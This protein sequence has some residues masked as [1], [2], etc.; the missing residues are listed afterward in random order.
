MK[1]PLPLPEL[2]QINV[3]KHFMSPVTLF[4]GDETHTE[5]NLEND[6]KL[7]MDGKKT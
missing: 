4:V 5:T 2:C 6:L 3:F 1:E 7:P